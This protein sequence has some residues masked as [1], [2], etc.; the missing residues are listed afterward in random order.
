MLWFFNPNHSHQTQNIPLVI[1]QKGNEK[2]SQ[3]DLDFC[4]SYRTKFILI[5]T[6]PT[7]LRRSAY[8][9]NNVKLPPDGENYGEFESNFLFCNS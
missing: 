6:L 8:F 3:R 1:M 5:A 7:T 2:L 4:L 9:S